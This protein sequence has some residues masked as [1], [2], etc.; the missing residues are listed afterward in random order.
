MP[1]VTHSQGIA[2]LETQ[3]TQRTPVFRPT[4]VH[5]V[6]PAV[7]AV[8]N[9]TAPLCVQCTNTPV[10]F[11]STTQ[12][13]V[14]AH[15]PTVNSVAPSTSKELVPVSQNTGVSGTTSMQTTSQT[16]DHNTDPFRKCGKKIH[17]T[18]KCK[19]KTSCN[20]C[21]SRE[22]KTMFC[23]VDTVPDQVCTFCGKS[24]HT[25]E[26]CRV[27]KKAEKKARAQESGTARSNV[28]NPSM[29]ATRQTQGPPTSASGMT[30]SQLQGQ[31]PMQVVPPTDD[32]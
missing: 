24:R 13:R 20:K 5:I 16:Q 6:D 9:T 11:A 26:C 22:H 19:K 2:L 29:T 4:P 28:S 7:A 25:A 31:Q 30:G 1:Q 12:V 21:K 15:S 23:T 8:T 17:K 27:C 18:D 3:S 10:C 32:R 14:A